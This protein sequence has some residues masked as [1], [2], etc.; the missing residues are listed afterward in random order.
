MPKISIR[1]VCANGKHTRSPS[2]KLNVFS[3]GSLRATANKAE[4]INTPLIILYYKIRHYIFGVYQNSY[5]HIIYLFLPC[6][7]T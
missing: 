3:L 6:T 1:V 4:S 7:N 5:A 2:F